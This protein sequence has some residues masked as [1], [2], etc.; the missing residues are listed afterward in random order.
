MSGS[1][2]QFEWPDDYYIWLCDMIDLDSHSGYSDLISFL[3]NTEFTWSVAKDV[4]RAEDGKA[5]RQDYIYEF[6]YDEGSWVEEPC[7]WLEMFVALARRIRVDLMPDY[8]MGGDYWFWELILGDFGQNYLPLF[9]K[10]GHF[11]PEM[12]Q[13]SEKKVANSKKVA[14]FCHDI[15][16][17]IQQFL[18]ENYDF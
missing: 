11:F 10:F 13:K 8:E 15:W 6:Y 4:N 16:S 1:F 3:Y 17:K 9:Q 2:K 14:S 7:S 5:L 18:A 12:W